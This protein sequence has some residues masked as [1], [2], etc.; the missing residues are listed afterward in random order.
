LGRATGGLLP[1]FKKRLNKSKK[2]LV[3]AMD[4]DFNTPVVLA[5]LFGLALEFQGTI[6]KIS[7]SEA[8]ELKNYIDKTMEILGIRLKTYKIPAGVKKLAVEREK[9]RGNKQ[10]M[11]SD[12]LRKKIKGLGYSLEDTPLGPWLKPI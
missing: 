7:T 11:Q 12:A 5:G 6:W 4:D 1:G 8:K 10:F 2:D 3:G 9:F